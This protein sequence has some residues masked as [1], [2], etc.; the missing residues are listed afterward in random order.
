MPALANLSIND[1]LATPV[2][3]TFSPIGIDANQ[4]ASFQDKVSGIPLGFGKIATSLRAPSSGGLQP[5]VNSAKSVYRA[6]L[7]IDIPVLE[8]TSPSTGSGIQPAPTVAYTAIANIEFVIPAR[9]S[10]QD[11]KD[12]L[13]FAKNLLADNHATNLVVNLESVW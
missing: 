9:S 1:G 5:G 2:A 10:L 8:V 12:I 13:A 3:H 6:R 11:R 4:V 7:K